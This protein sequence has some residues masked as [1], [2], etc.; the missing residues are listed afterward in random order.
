[1]SGIPASPP[2]PP[3]H[4]R[5]PAFATGQVLAGRFRIVRFLA[6]G[7]MGE[8]YEAEDV[9]VRSPVALKTVR[10]EV[11]AEP[12]VIERFRRELLLSRR[13]TH[14]NVCRIFDVFH[15]RPE[16]GAEDAPTIF[17]VMELL[18]GETLAARLRR[19]GRM[20]TEEA[21]PIVVQMTAALAAAHRAGIVHRDFKSGNVMLVPTETQDTRTVVTDFGLARAVGALDI[22]TSSLTGSGGMVGTSAYMA[23]EQVEGGDVTPAADIYALGVVI[24]E[25]VTATKPF[26]GDSPFSTA[27]RRLKEPAPSPRLRVPDLDP[28]WEAVILRSLSRDPADRFARVE[29]VASALTGHASMAVAPR[30]APRRRRRVASVAAA[31]VTIAV[32]S[33][34]YLAAVGRKAQSPGY[35]TAALVAPFTARRSVALIGFKNLSGRDDAA[36]LSTAL[37]EMLATELAAGSKLRTIPA[38]NVA[39]MKIDLTLADTESLGKD[40]LRLVRSNLGT[41]LVVL[42]SYL[43]L[44]RDS[45][46]RI[47]LDLRI[48]D[49]A[50][51]ETIASVAEVGTEAEL[52]DLVSRAGSHLRERLGVEPLS[53][54]E[55]QAVASSRPASGEAL[56]LYAEGLASLR[57]LDARK[58]RDLLEKAVAADP[59][60]ALAHAA[61]A[62][63][64]SALGYDAKAKEEART[65][66]DLSSGLSREE[67]LWIEARYRE[68]AKE[69]PR[70][71]EV[72]RSLVSLFPD[73]LDYGLQLASAQGSAGKANDALVTIASL[74]RLRAP[75]SED[76]RIDL[77]E[78][79]AKNALSDY[80]SAQAA[81]A[82]A[83]EKG[84]EQHARLLV[85][86]ALSRS[87]RILDE[88]GDKQAAIAALEEARRIYTAAQD[89]AGVARTLVDLGFSRWTSGDPVEAQKM[90]DSAL[91]I[92]HRIGDQRGTAVALN[93]FAIFR[94]REGRVDEARRAWEQ[95][96]AAYR[97]IGDRPGIAR[98]LNNIAALV[99]MQGD[100][101]RA[102]S[103]YEEALATQRE[104]G[105]RGAMAVALQNVGRIASERGDL[106]RALNNYD[107]ALAINRA[108]GERS[109][110][111]SSLHRIAEVMYAEGNLTEARKKEEEAL[112][113]LVQLGEELFTP[114]ARVA[115]ARVA[116]EEGRA[117]EAEAMARQAAQTFS[118]HKASDFEAA[119]QGLLADAL[120]AQGKLAEARRAAA[121]AMSLAGKSHSQ[122]VRLSVAIVNA[123]VRAAGRSPADTAAALRSLQAVRAEAEKADRRG[124]SFEAQLAL[125][126]VELRAGQSAAGRARLEALE[127]E[128]TARGFRLV[129]GKA[130]ALRAPVRGD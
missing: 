69:W 39:R 6:H 91:G 93:S 92:F 11:A 46:G 58:A 72:Y 21:L 16:P 71:V 3:A 119:A 79:D 60:Y 30:Q 15:H 94:W 76:A 45:G 56:R 47:R 12:Q 63:A 42:G 19:Q 108:T 17:L 115:L 105:D 59:S 49:A 83:V 121:R 61:L 106:G 9:E 23:P 2:S 7:G 95:S 109:S 126:E 1:M 50:A 24:Y 118:K 113:I 74:R 26:V 65:A 43:S 128:A 41:D 129:A 87:G 78:A 29:E 96:L 34:G 36:W 38:E 55:V 8:V 32:S 54:A 64:W 70:A 88:L 77:V 68:T 27:L 123:R 48:Q 124:L 40:T 5:A 51:G 89:A 66:F 67:T 110:I 18:A 84:R 85:A 111:A 28:V 25:M 80:K 116:I 114:E 130:A 122:R 120:L 13:V 33:L 44:G 112:A 107:Q 104:A 86:R 10:P 117:A 97:E 75:S 98:L 22:S 99:E 101:P 62:Q 31:L 81:A 73:N 57:L 100:L 4:G 127:R 35:G 37:A 102:A 90:Y 125:G 53:A 20:S 103:M 82:R 52:F 14:P